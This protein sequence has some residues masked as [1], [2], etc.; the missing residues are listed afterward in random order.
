[1]KGREIKL[2]ALRNMLQRDWLLVRRKAILTIAYLQMTYLKPHYQ[3]CRLL[4]D[5]RLV[6]T[7]SFPPKSLCSTDV[8]CERRGGRM[9]NVLNFGSGGPSWSIALC[10]WERHLT[11][12][13]PLSTQVYK[14]VP[15]N[16]LL[17]VTLRWTSIPSRGR[18]SRRTLSRIMLRNRVKLRPDGPLGWYADLTFFFTF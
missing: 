18:G 4:V 1:M 7:N 9:V 5:E 11:L 6:K 2:L 14:W 12:T 10:S 8:P 3:R 17:G 16:L 13:V 15:A